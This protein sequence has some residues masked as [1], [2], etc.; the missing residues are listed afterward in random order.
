MYFILNEIYKGPNKFNQNSN[1]KFEFM[2]IVIDK[3]DFINTIVSVPNDSN[4]WKS[5]TEIRGSM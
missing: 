1:Y 2:N 3:L 4:P 5:F